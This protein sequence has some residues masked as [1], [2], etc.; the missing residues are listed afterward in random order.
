MS[1]VSQLRRRATLAA[2]AGGIALAAV[3]GA[4]APA[5]AYTSFGTGGT[6]VPSP[7]SVTSANYSVNPATASYSHNLTTP[8]PI[9]YRTTNSSQRIDTT[10]TIWKWSSSQGVWYKFRTLSG[11]TTITT[12]VLSARTNPLDTWVNS[13]PG[14]YFVDISV[15][16]YS[17]LG[18]VL[19]TKTNRTSALADF[20]CL[21]YG[22]SNSGTGFVTLS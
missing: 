4:A 14:S 1:L 2:V 16:W 21:N 9:V 18:A 11:S 17:P 22:C 3:T 12:A 13:S 8:G 19:Y 6:V 20:R 15:T 5:N 7:V 10:Y